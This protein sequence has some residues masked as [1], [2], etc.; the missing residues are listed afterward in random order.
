MVKSIK[1][2]IGGKEYTLRGDDEQLIQHAAHEVNS[3]LTELEARHQDESAAT[4]AILA[5]LNIAE[6]Y[7]KQEKASRTETQYIIDE[8]NSVVELIEANLTEN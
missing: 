1:I 8:I 2:V 7:Y 3:Q 6:E 5:A 4:L